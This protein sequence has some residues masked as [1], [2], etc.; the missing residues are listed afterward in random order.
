MRPLRIA[1][2]GNMCNV[3]YQIAKALRTED[4]TGI[5]H[6]AHLYIERSADLQNR[7]ESD[8]PELA[9]GN[10]EWVHVGDWM[11][12]SRRAVGILWPAALPVLREWSSYDLLI[13]CA[14]G[15][16]AARFAGRPYV[17]LTGGGDLTLMPFADRHRAEEGNAGWGHTLAWRVRAHWQRTGIR[18]ATL[19]VT[20]PFGPF[21]DALAQLG[22]SSEQVASMTAVLALDTNRFRRHPNATLPPALA[23]TDFL[24]FHPSRLMMRDDPVLRATGQWKANEVLLRGFAEFVRSGRAQRPRL[25]LIDRQH[26]RDIELARAE[27]ARLG[28]GE[29]V[30]WLRGPTVEG[31]NRNS[32]FEVYSVSHVVADDFGAGWFGSVALEGCAAECAVLTYVDENAMHRMYPWHPFVNARTS[33]DVAQQLARLHGDPE[34]RAIIGQRSREWV[35]E[36]HSPQRHQ[37]K[38]RGELLRHAS[39]LA[40]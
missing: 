10:P 40:R 32:L 8:D 6:D 7:P 3:L 38:L 26:G 18:A 34:L 36:F 28:I 33:A 27:I 14:E 29:H 13:V 17:F 25:A 30:V 35:V 16:S 5:A 15:P 2:Y 4:E 11:R 9:D 21:V 39:Q 23:G 31:F 24:V 20:Q 37:A 1:L 22:V 12:G 19:V